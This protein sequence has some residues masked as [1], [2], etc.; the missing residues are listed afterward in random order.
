MNTRSAQGAVSE[1]EDARTLNLLPPGEGIGPA[2]LRMTSGEAAQL[3]PQF[4]AQL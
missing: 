1:A 4:R 2:G 3:L